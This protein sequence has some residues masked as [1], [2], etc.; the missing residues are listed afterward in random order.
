MFPG[1]NCEYD[2]AKAMMDAGAEAE[3]FV[4]RNL[5]AAAIAQS[6]EEFAGKLK[7]TQMVF[8]PGGFSGGMSRTALPNSSPPFFRNAAVRKRLQRCWRSGTV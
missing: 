7:Q 4:I 8:L 1:T 3:I 6:V 2:S 5:T